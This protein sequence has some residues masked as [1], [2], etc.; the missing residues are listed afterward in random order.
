[1][2]RDQLVKAEGLVAYQRTKYDI[3]RAARL[4]DVALWTQLSSSVRAV[5]KIVPARYDEKVA[6]EATNRTTGYPVL[7]ETGLGHRTDEQKAAAVR[8]IAET[9]LE[10]ADLLDGEGY[11]LDILPEGVSLRIVNNRTL[12]GDHA[13]VQAAKEAEEEQERQHRAARELAAA[14]RRAAVA[15][16]TQGLEDLGLGGRKLYADDRGNV[17]INVAALAVLIDRAKQAGQGSV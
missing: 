4:L 7:L 8:F 3:P 14:S 6:K 1:M 12:I 15:L 13:S 10:M 9:E 16:I 5:R 2:N 11:P 17:S